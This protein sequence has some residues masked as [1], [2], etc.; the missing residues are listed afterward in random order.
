MQLI[1]LPHNCL[2]WHI[3]FSQAIHFETVAVVPRGAFIAHGHD[4]KMV[5]LV[6]KHLPGD[7]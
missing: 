4:V 3:S 1:C 2:W 7:V 5:M 6:Y